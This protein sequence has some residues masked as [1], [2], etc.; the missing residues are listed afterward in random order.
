MLHSLE[1]R[2]CTA[3]RSWVIEKETEDKAVRKEMGTSDKDLGEKNGTGSDWEI[4]RR[5]FKD[6]GNVLLHGN[7][8]K[9]MI[10]VG[11]MN[12]VSGVFHPVIAVY[13]A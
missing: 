6:E 11:K 5:I 4:E 3:W 7:S 12:I 1:V 9:G 10:E 8:G 13:S 2:L